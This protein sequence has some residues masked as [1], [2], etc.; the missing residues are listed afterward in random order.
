M[1]DEIIIGVDLGGT[2]IR[3]ARLD[4]HLKIVE[5]QETLT[6]AAEGKEPTLQ[7]IKDQIHKVMPADGEVD[8]IGISA[9]GPLNPE[10]GVIV[11]PP[12]LPGWHNV[13]L[14][15]ILKDEFKVPVY[16]GNDANV[17]VLAEALR[18]AAVGCSHAIYITVSTGIGGGIIS[19]GRMV[20]GNRGLAAEAGHITIVVG[21]RVTTL[22]K[23][24]AGPSLARKCRERI[25]NGEASKITDIVEGKLEAISGSTVAEAL[26]A[27]DAL[28]KDVVYTGARII[29][30]GMVT[31]L[32]LFNPETIV[33]GGGVI[34]GMGHVMLPIIEATI[35][36]N[37]ID[38]AYWH[39]LDVKTAEL[40]GDVSIIG[41]AALVPIRGGMRRIDE[42]AAALAEIAD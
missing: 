18:G 38:E 3:T 2:R 40:G 42:V 12:N 14:G 28:A 6:L 5:R 26:E 35:H 23:E 4:D 24:A 22:E 36:E 29:G 33:F 41:A 27:G 37:T 30:L 11:A 7:R 9:P 8:G 34:T 15:D 10:T 21:D 20:L 19:D 1:K 25:A 32:H 17:A 39:E 31:L 16:T 13:P